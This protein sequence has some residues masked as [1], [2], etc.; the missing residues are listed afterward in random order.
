MKIFR[1]RFADFDQIDELIERLEKVATVGYAEKEPIYTFDF[2]PNDTY[3]NGNNKW[4]HTLV[5]SEAAWDISQGS[6][7]VKVAIVDNAVFC[8]H[9]D[10]TTFA[11]RAHHNSQVS[12]LVGHMER[13]VQVLQQLISITEPE[14]LHLEQMWN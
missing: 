5:G 12:I 9:S 1:I 3:H 7:T 2:I 10:L 13:T 14:L 11:Q 6:N 8:G 4:Y